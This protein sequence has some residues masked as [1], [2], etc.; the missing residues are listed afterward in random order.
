MKTIAAGEFKQ[1]CLALL[2]EVGTSGE[3]IVVTKRGQAVAQLGPVSADQIGDWR[4]AMRGQGEIIGDL[5]APAAD[6]GE[7]EVLRS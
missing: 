6:E 4:A 5:V 7:W 2:D 3:P 1:R